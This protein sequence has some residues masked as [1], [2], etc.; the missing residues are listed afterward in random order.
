MERRLWFDLSGPAAEGGEALLPPELPAPAASFP[1]LS[2]ARNEK[3]ITE[4]GTKSEPIKTKK[5]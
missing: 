5:K 1:D 3:Q 2:L 4:T